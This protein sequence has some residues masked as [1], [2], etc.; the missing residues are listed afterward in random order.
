MTAAISR[1]T[2]RP[3]RNL[4]WEWWSVRIAPRYLGPLRFSPLTRFAG[5]PRAAGA[6]V[7]FHSAL[8]TR[9]QYSPIPLRWPTR[10]RRWWQI[11]WICRDTLESGAFGRATLRRIATWANDW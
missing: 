3:A 6:D 8:R 5:L 9:S 7:V 1:Y 2:S 4:S 11:Q 10:R